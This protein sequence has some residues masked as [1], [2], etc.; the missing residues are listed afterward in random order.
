MQ[1]DLTDGARWLI[2]E[3]RAA[4]RR[5]GQVVLHPAAP[6][7]EARLPEAAA[8]SDRGAEIDLED[9][10][11][12]VRQELDLRIV[13]PGIATHGPPCGWITQGSPRA[14]RPSGSVR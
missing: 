6:F 12:A 5:V 13:R 8:E 11:A 7:L 2:A 3:G 14:S 9:R 1:D 10:I 4:A